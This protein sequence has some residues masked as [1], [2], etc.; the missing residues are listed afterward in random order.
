[1]RFLQQ[2]VG[3]LDMIGLMYP[4]TP[5]ADVRLTRNHEALVREVARFEGRKFD[6]RPRNQFEDQYS[7][8]PAEV[9][10]RIRNQVS[11]SALRSIITRLGGIREGRK[12]V[13]LVSEGYSNYLP[14]QLRDPV[15]DM[16]AIG[17]RNR[18]LP[19]LGDNSPAEDRARFFSDIDMLTE[20]REVYSAANR[21]NTAIYALDPRGLAPFEYDIGQGVGTRIDQSML[22]QT[23]D[24]LRVLADQTDGRAIVNRNDLEGGLRQIVRDAS[25]YYLIGYNSSQA[26]QDGK[27]HEIKV[28]VKRPGV[29]VRARKGYWA[30]TAEETAR[31]LAPP[32]PG[33][34][35]GI[36]QALASVENPAR[37]RFVRTWIGT[38]PSEGGKTRINFVWEAV[39]A[40]PGERRSAPARVSVVAAG[41]DTMYFR[42]KVEP[43]VAAS[44][45]AA[46]GPAAAGARPSAAFAEFDADPGRLQLR[47]SVEDAAGAV[48]DSD[49]LDVDVPDYTA[50]EVRLT[51]L[52][53]LRARTAIEF[54]ALGADPAAVPVA[55]REF[56][57][58]ERLLIRFTTLGPGTDRPE[59]S[60]R[61]LNRAGQ[62]MSDLPAQPFGSE[63]PRLQIDLPLAGLAPGEYIVEVTSTL[64]DGRARQFLGFR[65]VS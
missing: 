54:R 57:R 40:V 13:I 55:T 8:Y 36:A 19:G 27:F 58:T 62:R 53:V 64:G 56:R 14:P 59:T 5:V 20:L 17:N 23:M 22:N 11:L 41:G 44:G 32:A 42:G 28:R 60:A 30:L 10:E 52:E 34:D 39:P 47:L 18:R 15:A 33:P 31:A 1:M 3:P 51:P 6:Y 37:A 46:A 7:M 49:M 4:L 9:V 65:V 2:H 63:G 24:S 48:I 12:S 38:T 43:S 50:P 45:V 35:P 26:P 21:S 29:Q 25:A 61:L 16:P